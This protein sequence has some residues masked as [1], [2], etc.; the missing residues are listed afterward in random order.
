[1][2]IVYS[3][4]SLPGRV[5]PKKKHVPVPPFRNL[6]AFSESFSA[7]CS[8]TNQHQQEDLFHVPGRRED[9][10]PQPVEKILHCRRFVENEVGHPISQGIP[11]KPDMSNFRWM[12]MM[13]SVSIWVCCRVFLATMVDNHQKSRHQNKITHGILYSH[14]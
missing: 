6:K 9:N 4:V 7:R 10:H 2:V 14:G 5:K 11:K 13:F 3:Y 8:D 1:M 12:F